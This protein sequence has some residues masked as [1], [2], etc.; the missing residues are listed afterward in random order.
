MPT[1]EYLLSYE[2]ESPGEVEDIEQRLRATSPETMT[3]VEAPEVCVHGTT[4]TRKPDGTG[5]SAATTSRDD[6]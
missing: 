1:V 2:V 6:D 4:I 5:G 3:V